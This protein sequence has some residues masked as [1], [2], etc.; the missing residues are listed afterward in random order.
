MAVYYLPR[1]NDLQKGLILLIV[2]IELMTSMQNEQSNGLIAGLIILSFGLL[3][4]NKPLPASLCIVFSA[5]VKLFGVVGFALFLFYPEKW[6]SALY[7]L[8]WITIM[9]LVPLLF[10]DHHQYLKLYGSYLNLLIND[11]E[12]SYGYSVMGLLH[13]WFSAAIAKNLVIAAGTLVFLV[14]LFRYKMY[15]EFIFRLLL[16]CSILIW[17]VIF[18]HK[19]E[20]PTFIIAMSGVAMWF[21]ASEKNKVN[22]LLFVAAFILTT[23]SPTDIFPH[24][25]REAFVKPYVLKVLPCILV[26]L[27]IIYDMMKLKKEDSATRIAQ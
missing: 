24:Y 15:K 26:W 12:A 18:N 4:R 16:L 25:L 21:I 3:E 9:L 10:V 20:S 7:S 19:A 1:L 23:L 17:I 6:K 5:F 11:H 13:A 14:P 22:V 8:L 2:L 27:K